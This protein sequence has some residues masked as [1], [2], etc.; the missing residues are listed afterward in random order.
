MAVQLRR[1][2]VL[3][4]KMDSLLDWLPA[5]IAVREQYGFRVEFMYADREHNQLV[6]AVS[7]PGAVD[8]FEAAYQR[9]AASLE[10]AA[11]LEGQPDRVALAHV[12]MVEPII[13]PVS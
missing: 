2:E 7:H 10:R 3:E 11:A 5:I 9:F 4:G 6:W 8:A 13:S 1:Y 12:A